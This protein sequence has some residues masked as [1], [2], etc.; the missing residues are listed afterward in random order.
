MRPGKRTMR[1]VT[2]AHPCP[3]CGRAD[4][5]LLA[6]DDAAAICARVTSARRA[7]AAGWLHCLDAPIAQAPP[8]PRV[9]PTAP[10]A[11][12]ADLDRAYR[13]LLALLPLSDAH[14]QHLRGRGLSDAD[15]DRAA[16]RTLPV[17]CRA[18]L[19]RRL[20]AM[21]GAELLLSVPGIIARDGP[22]GRYL[23][24]S[25]APGIVN[26]IR[27]AAGLVV[28][29]VV[30]PDEPGD[31]GKYRW[32]SSRSSGGPSPGW[33]VHV[34]AGTRPARRVVLTEGALKATVAAALSGGPVIGLPGCIVTAEAITTL[35]TLGAV[36]A[37]LALDAD[38]VNNPQVASAQ[39]DGLHQLNM[40]GFSA[41]LVRWDLSLGKGLDDLFLT[42]MDRAQ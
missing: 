15:L 12:D 42:L 30:R 32:V 23:T 19:V 27:S 11:D 1:R 24:L 35:K 9:R 2:R 41:G 6:S 28:G 39:I 38:A 16:F 18:G 8:P 20:R 33:R 21:F 7:G 29:L 4:W 13:A 17:G 3:I 25:G 14:R 37:L 40:A 5:C 34:P 31:G 36:E 10:R 22:H 26:P